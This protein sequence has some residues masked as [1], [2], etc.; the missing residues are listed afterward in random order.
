MILHL[1]NPLPTGDVVSCLMR[2]NDGVG[3]IEYWLKG[4]SLGLAF[5]RINLRKYVWY[6]AA[7][8][9]T[10]QMCTFNFG[11]SQFRHSAPPGFVSVQDAVV[12]QMTGVVEVRGHR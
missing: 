10:D 3:E 8:F 6:P 2:N 12:D 11:A 1:L 5:A 4:E 9:A 7:S